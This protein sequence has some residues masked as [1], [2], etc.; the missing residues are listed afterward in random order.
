MFFHSVSSQDVFDY[1]YISN[2][3]VYSMQYNAL[4]ALAPKMVMKI[5]Y[6]LPYVITIGSSLL[7][8][9]KRE[10]VTTDRCFHFPLLDQNHYQNLSTNQNTVGKILGP[11]FQ[12][13]C[14]DENSILVITTIS[15]L[16]ALECQRMHLIEFVNLISK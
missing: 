13:T 5:N 8:G 14:F 7:L 16:L 1:L 11:K 15:H 2:I 10:S 4:L 12:F 6:Q 3:N 9:R